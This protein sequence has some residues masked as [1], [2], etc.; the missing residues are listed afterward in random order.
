MHDRRIHDDRAIFLA[1][2]SSLHANWPKRG[3]RAFIF[4]FFSSQKPAFP[5]CRL[6]KVPD[7][8]EYVYFRLQEGVLVRP[9]GQLDWY[10]QPGL[11]TRFVSRS[12]DDESLP[13]TGMSATESVC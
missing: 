4:Q 8:A 3:I 12:G 1:F 9:E 13:E 11:T 2:D 5:Q 6:S 7:L 10:N